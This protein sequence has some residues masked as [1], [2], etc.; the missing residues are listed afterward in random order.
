MY[1]QIPQSAHVIWFRRFLRRIKPNFS[2]LPLF[3]VAQWF[4]MSPRFG[5]ILRI[6]NSTIIVKFNMT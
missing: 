1:Q 3:T 6:Q 2:W 5:S 4:P